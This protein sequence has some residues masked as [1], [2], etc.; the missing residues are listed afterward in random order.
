M[1]VRACVMCSCADNTF[2]QTTSIFHIDRF[3]L[4]FECIRGATQS[5]WDTNTR[6]M[7]TKIEHDV[8]NLSPSERAS[9]GRAVVVPDEVGVQITARLIFLWQLLS[10]NRDMDP[11]KFL[12]FQLN[13][14][15]AVLEEMI[16][17]LHELKPDEVN[18]L[19]TTVKQK[20]QL[21]WGVDAKSKIAIALDEANVADDALEGY[22]VSV[23]QPFRPVSLLSP[24]LAAFLDWF[25]TIFAGTGTR[26]TVLECC[27]C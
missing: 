20:L 8:S 6:R 21:I 2:L 17:R 22:F 16:S 14:G 15:V 3:V 1:C 19:A 7:I 23:V 10:K 26:L 18:K 4:Y 24:L 25:P 27:M 11:L 13:G 12:Q 5:G 9:H